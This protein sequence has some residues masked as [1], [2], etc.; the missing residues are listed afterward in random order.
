[1]SAALSS[2]TGFARAD[3]SNGPLRVRIEIKSV[4]GRGLDIRTRLAPG[5]DAFDLPVRQLLSQ[6]LSRGSVNVNLTLDR[7]A[8]RG[9][10]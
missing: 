1:M 10:A 3:A 8:A 6:A 2:M 7:G 4:N 9:P 5:L